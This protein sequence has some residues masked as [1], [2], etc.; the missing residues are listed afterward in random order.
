MLYLGIDQHANQLTIDL[1]DED[2]DLVLHR[3][4][5]TRWDSLRT[6]LEDLRKQAEPEGGYMANVEVCGFNDYL[7]ELLEE[8]GC[9]HVFLVQP[10]SRGNRKTDRRDARTLREQ[11]WMNR[12]RLREGTRPAGLRVVRPATPE[13]AS[14]RQITVLHEKLTGLRTRA[15]NKVKTILRKHNLQHDCPTKGI[16]TKRARA[17]LESL[18]LPPVDRLEMTLLLQ[19]WSLFDTQLEQVDQEVK[20]R[21]QKNEVALLLRSIPGMG[22]FNSLTVASRI[23]AIEDFPRGSSL[24][25]YWGLTPGSRNSDGSKIS[26]HITKAGSSRV[27]FSLGQVV[28][29]VLRKDGWMRRWYQKIK[30]RR[31]SKIARVAVMRR[32]ATIIWS[33]VKYRIT[34]MTGGPEKFKE[35]VRQHREFFGVPPIASV[36]SP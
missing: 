32:L 17:W 27:R 16:K 4:V 28:L 10:E 24:A 33:M 30:R 19:Q 23:G 12:T 6:F 5:K 13:D 1:G 36:T 25:N 26:L 31:G 7:L 20:Q 11:L 3:Q 15:I 8:Y 9:R 18:D 29:H 14:A 22:T 2:G 35:Y 21:Q 34:Y